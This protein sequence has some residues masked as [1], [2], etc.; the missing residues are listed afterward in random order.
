MVGRAGTTDVV[1][2]S[3]GDVIGDVEVGEVL[4]E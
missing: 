3:G 1:E 4:R 2:V